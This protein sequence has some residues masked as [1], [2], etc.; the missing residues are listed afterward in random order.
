MKSGSSHPLNI[1][2]DAVEQ[3]DWTFARTAFDEGSTFSSLFRSMDFGFGGD[4][5]KLLL[6]V[7]D[8]DGGAVSTPV[9]R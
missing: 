4:C 1:W 8:D 6:P 2:S 7:G 5:R 3:S 9:F